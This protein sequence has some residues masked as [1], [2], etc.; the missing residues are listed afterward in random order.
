MRR[1]TDAVNYLK[2][3][4]GSEFKTFMVSILK[5]LDRSKA[6]KSFLTF[7]EGFQLYQKANLTRKSFNTIKSLFRRAGILDPTL[8]REEIEKN[9]DIYGAST[10]FTVVET[11]EKKMHAVT[12]FML[13][14]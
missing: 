7:F 5:E 4:G 2:V 6:F 9:E 13:R 14:C 8:S 1:V 12:W 11:N 3:I 10:M